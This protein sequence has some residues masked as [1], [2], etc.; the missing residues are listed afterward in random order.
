MM[1]D[2]VS[3]GIHEARHLLFHFDVVCK[4]GLCAAVLLLSQATFALIGWSQHPIS[5]IGV[6]WVAVGPFA[7]MI[8]AS[9]LM[10]RV[11]KAMAGRNIP[12]WEDN[13]AAVRY[14]QP[15]FQQI[16]G[17]QVMIGDKSSIVEHIEQKYGE[18][19][20][21]FVVGVVYAGIVVGFIYAIYF[22]VRLMISDALHLATDNVRILDVPHLFL[23]AL[24]D[25][26]VILLFVL[27]LASFGLWFRMIVMDYSI[28]KQLRK[29]VDI[30]EKMDRTETGPGDQVP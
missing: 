27:L 10:A 23:E 17:G 30:L 11:Q 4:L 22:M 15:S 19:H 9:E 28:K 24:D 2:R 16:P 29:V 14:S 5:L 21:R 18:K 25:S 1:P 26:G 6:I 8:I 13:E 3:S 20:G 7:A 12:I